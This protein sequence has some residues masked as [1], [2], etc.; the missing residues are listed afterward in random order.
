MYGLVRKA[1]KLR[2]EKCVHSAE[3]FLV[4]SAEKTS[5]GLRDLLEKLCLRSAR[6]EFP[7]TGLFDRSRACAV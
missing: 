4:R 6:I 1:E 3:T 5:S 2:A 7:Q